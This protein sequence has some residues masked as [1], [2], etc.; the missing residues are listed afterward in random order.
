MS[1]V[2]TPW[3][4]MV[5]GPGAVGARRSGS[6]CRGRCQGLWATKGALGL[7][8]TVGGASQQQSAAIM[9][10]SRLP[11]DG[12]THPTPAADTSPQI[13]NNVTLSH[14]SAEGSGGV[15]YVRG[16]LHKGLQLQVRCQGSW[17]PGRAPY[18]YAKPR[19]SLRQT[20]C[21]GVKHLACTRMQSMACP[22]SCSLLNM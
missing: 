3:C 21:S 18:L 14:N 9:L 15:L 8:F 17:R 5:Q 16:N 20:A 1:A 10:G 6:T 13:S 12:P 4:R 2:H 19:V 11:S 7:E 22:S